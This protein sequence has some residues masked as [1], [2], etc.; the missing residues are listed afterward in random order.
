MPEPCRAIL[1]AMN[2]DEFV[3]FLSILTGIR[4][5]EA[6][7]A[8]HGGGLHQITA[9]GLLDIHT[10]FNRHALA[11]ETRYRRLNVLL[12]ANRV[13]RDEWGGHL[14]LWKDRQ[15]CAARIE[16][17]FNRLVVFATSATSWHGHPYPLRCPGTFTLKSFASYFYASHPAK[18]DAAVRDTTWAR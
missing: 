17:T 16:P 15:T 9:D 1:E 10:D 13:W 3:T 2:S 5:L 4:G 14:E 8:Y 7:P 11:G 12:F 18:G 6:D